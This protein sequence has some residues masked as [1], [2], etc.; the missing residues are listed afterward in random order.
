MIPTLHALLREAAR[1]HS[2]SEA[3]LRLGHDAR[4]RQALGV[5]VYMAAEATEQDAAAIAL[6]A[7]RSV[8]FCQDALAHVEALIAGDPRFSTLVT[9]AM[10]EAM[11]L[12]GLDARRRRRLPELTPAEIARRLLGGRADAITLGSRH[13]GQIAAAYLAQAEEIAAR[14]AEI[15]RLGGQKVTT[16]VV[17]SGALRAATAVARAWRD[18]ERDQYSP[19]VRFVRGRLERAVAALADIHA[20]IVKPTSKETTHV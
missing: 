15:K 3:D 16:E 4:C 19:G 1:L 2:L 20:P 12:D 5:Y 10:I 17:A 6:Y 18:Y 9:E 8:A 11:A 13:Y 7:G 14:D